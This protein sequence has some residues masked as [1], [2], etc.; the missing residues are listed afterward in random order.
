MSFEKIILWYEENV[1]YR[2]TKSF[3]EF[4]VKIGIVKEDID[5]DFLNLYLLEK[6]GND[7]I[8]ENGK[9]KLKTNRLPIISKF[10]EE[11]AEKIEP[12]KKP[13]VT[14]IK[15]DKEKKPTKKFKIENVGGNRMKLV[16]M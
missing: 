13:V 7:F 4:L 12:I 11:I 2:L 16:K 1:N 6:N 8:V 5:L 3:L 15:A 9:Y 10:K 14:F